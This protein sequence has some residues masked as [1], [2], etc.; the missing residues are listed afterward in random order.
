M[1]FER[2][3]FKARDTEQVSFA[4]AFFAL[5]LPAFVLI[6]VFSPAFFARED[7]RTPMRYA[8]WSLVINTAGSVGLFF[9]FRKIGYPPHV[10]I[11]I[12]TAVGG[13]INAGLLFRALKKRGHFQA[14]RRLKLAMPM[15]VMSAAVLGGVL[16]FGA[17]Y[18][19]P[20][21]ASGVALPVRAGA[22]AA[23]VTVGAIAYFT[24]ATMTGAL[25]LSALKR[26]ISRSK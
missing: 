9:L 24:I 1:L 13:W 14:D 23:L 19:R 12:A 7:T 18:L 5:G 6:K 8:G 3:A 16:L 22:L 11:A 4:L 10:G 21:F 26:A 15:I 17:D 2:G 20:W 25:R